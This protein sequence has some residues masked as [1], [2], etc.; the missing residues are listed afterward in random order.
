LFMGAALGAGFAR[1]VEPIWTITEIDTGAFAVVGMAAM[2]AMVG[3]APL[4]SILIV[5]E[6]TGARDYGLIVPL[7]LAATLATFFGERF[8]K[9]SVYTQALKRMGIRIR[10][11]GDVDILDTVEVGTVMAPD[12]PTVNPEATIGETEQRLHQ[13]RS[14]GVPVLEDGRLI[15]IVTMSDISRSEGGPDTPVRE[16]MTPRPVTVTPSTPVSRALER[17]AALGV[18]RLPVVAEHNP[19]E[20]VG[21][22]RREEAVR[23]YHEGLTATTDSELHRMRLAQRTDPG[24][25]YFDFRIPLGSMA[26][27]RLVRE[28]SW[29]EGSTLVSIRRN[30][31]VL[32]PSGS[33]TLLPGDVITAFGT[34]TSKRRMIDRLNAGAEEPTAEIDLSELGVEDDGEYDQSSE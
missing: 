10:P 26:D 9:E 15:G 8:A 32:I 2:F 20:V 14:H 22:F 5:F 23:A 29:P 21:M 19:E 27:G 4:T 1:L 28:V 12:P 17:M 31:D 33:T 11:V 34:E 18:G 25:G 30:R 16:V 6:I 7:M 3:R 13:I 24:A